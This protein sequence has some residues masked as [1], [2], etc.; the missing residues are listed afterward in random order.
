VRVPFAE[1]VLEKL[2][3]DGTMAQ[4]DSVIGVCSSE[5]ERDVFS[6]LAFQNVM[7]TNI[8]AQAGDR[9]HPFDWSY[10]DA[11]ELQFAAGSFDFAF[12]AD[13]L[14][15]CSCPH[16]ALLEMYR[17]ARKG[18]VIVESRDSLLMRTANRLGLSPEYEVEAVVGCEFKAGGVDNSAIPN[19][20]YRWTESDFKKA[21][22]SF[23][24]CGN[25]TFRFF[26]GLNLPYELAGWKK[27]SLK[28]RVITVTAPLLR[29]ATYFFKKQR[30]T[31]GMVALKPHIPRDL[32]P[33]LKVEDEDIVFNREYAA[34]HFKD[35]E[36]SGLG[37]RPRGQ[38]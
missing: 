31:F 29:G 25:Q 34:R 16:R 22:R 15:H 18:I 33:W 30:N 1:S 10:Q 13:G 17:V 14:H 26:Y 21:I 12:V 32:W 20:I 24:P 4:S 36:G 19:Y 35:I 5:R 7:L 28:I 6:H 38:T 27:S 8:D 3:A 37:A 9:F 2:V 11:Q 23:D